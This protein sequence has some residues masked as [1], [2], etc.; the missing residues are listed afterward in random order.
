MQ[1]QDQHQLKKHLHQLRQ[2]ARDFGIG[3][4]H[5][6]QR[7]PTPLEFMRL[8]SENRP[9]VITGATK[10]WPAM[11]KWVQREYLESVMGEQKMTVAV[12]PNG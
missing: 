7:P 5:Y 3:L 10:D 1:D 4:V 8:V 12:T 11:E 2:D 9:A 6:F